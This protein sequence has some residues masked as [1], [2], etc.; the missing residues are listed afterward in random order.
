MAI[1]RK[2][3]SLLTQDEWKNFVDAI[4]KLHDDTTNLNYQNF[5]DLHITAMTDSVGLTWA[6]HTMGGIDG[7]NFLVWHREYLLRLEEKLRSINPSVSIPYW[8][9]TEDQQIP[10][11]LSNRSDMQ[12]WNV[13]RRMFPPV[14]MLPSTDDLDS[15]TKWSDFKIFQTQLERLHGTPHNV[16]GG[17]MA[18]EASP[19]DPIFWL[20]H[21][22][23]DKIW[24]EWQA[25]NP[26]KNPDNLDE[27]LER[28]PIIQKKVGDLQDITV[29]GY[30]YI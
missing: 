17:D 18:S 4:H 25:A 12:K 16:V 24:S 7:R 19:Q 22:Y 23:I 15:V 8:N 14:W 1:Q 29:L 20:H 11:Q 3:Q 28:G 5:V 30:E 9:W 10:K 13:K 6:I 2:N 27:Q 26:G 21:S